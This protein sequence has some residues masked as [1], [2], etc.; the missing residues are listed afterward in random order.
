M[1]WPKIKNIIILI[2][3][4]TN[5]CLLAFA[6]SRGVGDR[7][8]QE[9]ARA[10]VISFLQEQGIEVEEELGPKAWI[11]SHRS[12]GVMQSRNV[13]WR[14]P[15]WTVRYLWKR[16]VPRCTATIIRMA[17]FSSTAMA[18][19]LPGFQPVASQVGRWDWKSTDGRF[20]SG[21]SFEEN[22]CERNR[23]VRTVL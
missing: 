11:F 4:G 10:N 14:L 6:V 21:W 22:C 8:Q 13:S 9:Q 5:F 1:A 12:S 3:L 7:K 23:R 19:F 2:L 16:E 20:W 18:S 15:C 17:L